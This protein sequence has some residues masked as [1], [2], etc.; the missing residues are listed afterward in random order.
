MAYSSKFSTS[1][2]ILLAIVRFE[3]E[4][5]QTSINL[6][7]SINVNPVIIRNLLQKLKKADLIYVK[8]GVGGAYLN[9]S[10]NDFSLFDIFKAVE[11]TDKD[12]FKKHENPNVDCP[13]G[14]VVH[15]VVN[16][17]FDKIKEDLFTSLKSIPFQK[18]VNEM[19]EN[20]DKTKL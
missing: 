4:E 3:K 6:A 17:N 19:Y 13:V 7:D 1:I 10:P 15:A 5:K 9:K 18:L 12:L 16:P 8:S 11:D 14:Q 2:H 20:L